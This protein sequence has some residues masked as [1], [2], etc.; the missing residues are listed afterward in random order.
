MTPRHELGIGITLLSCFAEPL[1]G[2][3]EILPHALAIVI[4]DPQSVLGTGIT[5]LGQWLPKFHCGCIVIA[6]IRCPP[7]FKIPRLNEA[8]CQ[9]QYQTD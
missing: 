9:N 4:Q 7:I 6:F 8:P 5:L 1:H 2:F 3:L